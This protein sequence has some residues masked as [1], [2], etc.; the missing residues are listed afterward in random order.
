LPEPVVDDTA[1]HRGLTTVVTMA[2]LCA[3]VVAFVVIGA[4]QLFTP[5][6][7]TDAAAAATQR[8]KPVCHRTKG[9]ITAGKVRVS[10]FN[11]S[12]RAGLAAETLNELTDR[13]FQLGQVGD[14]PKAKLK[15][16][17]VWARTANDAAAKLVA[18]QFGPDTVVKKGP[19]LGVG[20]DVVVGPDFQGLA[21]DAP[22]SIIPDGSQRVCS[23]D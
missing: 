12:D 4:R 8:T 11:A 18:L 19:N 22:T 6:H 15:F 13:G 7:R 5:I 10:V 16:V 17:Q 9:A 23:G 20:V 14:A 1:P 3:L 2:V 21:S